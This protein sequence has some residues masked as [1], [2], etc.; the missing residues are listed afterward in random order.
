MG[1]RTEQE[2]QE[3]IK[4]LYR[5]M[6]TSKPTKGMLT[7]ELVTAMSQHASLGDRI[8]ELVWVLEQ[9]VY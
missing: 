2:V 7:E 3:R 1:I 8:S 4:T 5:E 6:Q 9:P